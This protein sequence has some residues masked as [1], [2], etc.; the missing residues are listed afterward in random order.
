VERMTTGTTNLRRYELTQAVG[1]ISN[2]KVGRD[3]TGTGSRDDPIV[4]LQAARVPRIIFS[5]I[6]TARRLVHSDGQF[7]DMVTRDDTEVWFIVG[8]HSQ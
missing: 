5:R 4:F 7:Y 1:A 3:F 2:L 8:L 6:P